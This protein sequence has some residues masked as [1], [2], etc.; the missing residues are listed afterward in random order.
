MH[1]VTLAPL[2]FKIENALSQMNADFIYPRLMTH[3]SSDLLFW[4][5]Q[6]AHSRSKPG[7]CPFGTISM[8]IGRFSPCESVHPILLQLRLA[9][10]QCETAVA[11][12]SL[13]KSSSLH[14]ENVL[15]LPSNIVVVLTLSGCG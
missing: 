12:L 6:A 9:R 2:G 13:K 7:M 3:S 1:P 4:W 5:S 10:T 11:I 14:M 8:A 15:P